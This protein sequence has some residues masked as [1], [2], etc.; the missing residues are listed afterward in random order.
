MLDGVTP[1]VVDID[2]LAMAAT[3]LLDLFRERGM[4]D[5]VQRKLVGR[6][7]DSESVEKLKG[8]IAKFEA[9]IQA[10]DA[11]VAAAQAALEVREFMD[12]LDHMD[13]LFASFPPFST[14]MPSSGA[15]EGCPKATSKEPKATPTQIRS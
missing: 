14:K 11:K 13:A 4:D 10:H 5:S 7:L 12:H 15:T 3:D 8:L 9:A 1:P 6:A 2:D